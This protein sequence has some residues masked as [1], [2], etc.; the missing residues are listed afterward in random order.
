MFFRKVVF[1]EP[2]RIDKTHKL[3]IFRRL[4]LVRKGLYKP[5][6]YKPV[7]VVER[8]RGAEVAHPLRA[9]SPRRQ[10]PVQMRHDI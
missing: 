4:F 7:G 1:S 2:C 6:L 10:L 9:S 5:P 8:S 3:G